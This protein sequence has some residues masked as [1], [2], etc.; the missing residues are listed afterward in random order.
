M[1]RRAVILLACLLATLA[2]SDGR[3]TGEPVDAGTSDARFWLTNA[4]RDHAFTLAEAADAAGLTERQARAVIDAEPLPASARWYADD[5]RL[6]VLPYPG[7]RH[8]RIGFLDGA[9]DPWRST[10]ASIFT[11]WDAHAYAV[12]DLPEA[13]FAHTGL[14]FLA[15]THIPTVWEERDLEVADVP[16]QRHDDGAMSREHTLPDGVVIGARITPTI[17]GADLEL[18]L[19]NRTDE[20]LTNLRTQVCVMLKG[21][22][23]MNEQISDNKQLHGAVALAR[24][25]DGAPRYVLTAWERTGRT[26]ENPPVPCIHADPTFPDAQPGERVA[27]RGV[28]RF[29]EGDNVHSAVEQLQEMFSPAATR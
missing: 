25:T 10:K 3:A 16:W 4:M 21:L 13:V 20:P 2:G 12:V 14:I 17:N 19:V 22:A 27:V 9:I 26:W 29:H 28:I 1:A 7:G 24:A 11:P 5:D 15:H 18:W 6:T 23:G 8:P